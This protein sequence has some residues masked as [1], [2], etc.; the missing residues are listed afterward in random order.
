MSIKL[1][2]LLLLTIGCS[3][4]EE[5]HNP[6]APKEFS[7]PELILGTELLSKIF[8]LEMAPLTCVPDTE[9]AS[10]LLRTIK[11]RMDVVQEDMEA[12]LEDAPRVDKLINNC[13]KSCTCYYVDD[14]LRE[15]LVSL[16]KE[17]QKSLEKKKGPEEVNRC[18][19]YVRSTFCG[20]ELYKELNK[21][22]SDFSFEEESP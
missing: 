12:I 6:D 18:M 15:N 5:P 10:L 1:A 19:N 8:D 20:S 4:L 11:P 14:L 7:A 13:H 9:E 2:L 21:E 3:H 17:Q 22:K 16:S